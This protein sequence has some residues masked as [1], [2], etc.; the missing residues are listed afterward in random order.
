M[1]VYRYPAP[2]NQD[3]FAD[4]CVRLLRKI[5]AN[6][7][8][9]RYGKSGDK[10]DGVDVFDPTHS[11]P[12]RAAQCKCHEFDKYCPPLEIKAEA[13]KASLWEF[14]LDEFYILT[15]GK[16]SRFADD[17]ILKLNRDRDYKQRFSTI[18]WA[19][20][21]IERKLAELDPIA[22]DYVINASSNGSLASIYAVLAQ[23]LPTIADKTAFVSPND[24]LQKKLELVEQHIK[25]NDRRLSKYELD[26]IEQMSSA[27]QTAKDRYLV[28]RLNAK[29][30]MLI[31]EYEHAARRFLKAFDEQPDLDQAKINRAVAYELLGQKAEAWNQA[32]QLLSQ[33]IRTEP[34]PAI[35]YRIAPK[36]HSAKTIRYYQDQL[37]TSEDLNLVIADEAREDRRFENSIAACDQALAISASSSRA[38]LLRAFAYHSIAVQG[39]RNLRRERLEIAEN[40]YQAARDNITDRLHDHLLPDLYCNL[41]NVQYLLDRPEHA[42]SFQEAIRVAKDKYRYVERYLGYLC[43][44]T[45]F[46]TAERILKQYGIDDSQ[47]NQRFL[48]LVV[49]KNRS[50]ATESNRF[51]QAMLDLY[52]EGEF[53]RRDECLGLVVQWSIDSGRT[54]E[55][56]AHLNAIK[57]SVDPFEFHCCMAWLQHIEKD[58]TEARKSASSA[59]SLLVPESPQNYVYLLGRLFVDLDDDEAALPVL[60]QAAD[61]SRLT[62]ETRSLLDCAQRLQKH[63]VMLDVCRM[64]RNNKNDTKQSRSLELQVLYA[65]VPEQAKVLID[66]LVKQ[67]PDDRQLYAW[68]CHIETRLHGQFDAID[69]SKLPSASETSVYDSQRVIGPLLSTARY[70][71]AIRYAY[72]NLRSN[73]GDEVAHGRYMWIVMQ[74]AEKSDIPLF[75]DEV[76][77]EFVVQFRERGGELQS[78]VITDD[79]IGSRFDGEIS[80]NRELGKE[81]MHKKVGDDVTLSP[82]SLQPRVVKIEAVLSKYVYRYQQVL[83]NFQVNFPHA[84]TIQMLKVM[85][86]DEVDVSLFKRSL[87]ERRKHIDT[88]LD[89]F[90]QNPLPVSA[91]ALKQAIACL[92]ESDFRSAAATEPA[93]LV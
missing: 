91:L 26:Q 37:K 22:R 12:H 48:R 2:A 83:Q 61:W 33:G 78:V 86:G 81:L 59:K 87:E 46:E 8:F 40:D 16:K 5:F 3:D 24:Q 53:D 20:E 38:R 90:R 64:L 32:E 58:D 74:Y 51:I 77:P 50:P 55:A 4:F 43:A 27:I 62:P 68:L 19:W 42:V 66:E 73:Q 54:S 84:N 72:D 30:L 47:K 9:Q 89:L 44:R 6:E 14:E 65:Y 35:A 28:H 56:I 18:L 57:E 36:P 39:D 88:V 79:L 10:Q 23:L 70:G 13:E 21:D 17:A 25:N 45:D 41:A 52:Q 7:S 93:G 31:G 15:T 60:E 80:P 11:I 67:H 29:Y 75:A 63:D 82:Q 71:E 92:S 34:L 69:V 85:E 49:E 76:L 1:V